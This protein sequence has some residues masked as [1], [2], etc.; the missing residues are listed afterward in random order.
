VQFFLAVFGEHVGDKNTPFDGLELLGK[1]G[2]V[3]LA[4]ADLTVDI[5][6]MSFICGQNRTRSATLSVHL[7]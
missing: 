5:S 7:P 2:K 3:L 1:L 4:R 6:D